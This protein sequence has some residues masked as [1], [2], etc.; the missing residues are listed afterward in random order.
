MLPL[1][2]AYQFIP[3]FAEYL[4]G[5]VGL[6]QL[7]GDDG[8]DDN[9]AAATA[10]AHDAAAVGDTDTIAAIVTGA[11]AGAVSIIRLSGANAVPLAQQV[12]Q[13]GSGSRAGGKV[14]KPESHQ[15]Y[16]GRA[17]DAAGGTLD[18]VSGHGL[19]C[20]TGHVAPRLIMR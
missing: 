8:W 17:V 15:V 2:G 5:L 16:Y 19:Y 3:P 6:Q 12:F 11:A 18:E 13:P 4:A 14:W 7:V 10:A 20:C 9:T 1:H